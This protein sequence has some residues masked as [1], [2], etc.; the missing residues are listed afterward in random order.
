PSPEP[1]PPAANAPTTTTT[2]TTTYVPFGVPSPGTDINA[3]LPSSS[4]PIVGDQ[5]DSFDLGQSGRGPA[6]VTGEK[7]AVGLTGSERLSTAPDV[8]LVRKGDTLWDLCDQYF[9][10]PWQWP[11]VWS[12]NS[13]IQNP[14]WIY[15]GDQLRLRHPNE[16]GSGSKALTQSF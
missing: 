11:T 1:A 3:G 5:S 9:Q 15:P 4:R 2:T 10:N 6:V 14:H 12:Y 7:G 8:H 16:I 13:Q